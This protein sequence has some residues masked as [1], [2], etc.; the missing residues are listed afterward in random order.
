MANLHNLLN[1]ISFENLP[2]AWT[3]FDLASF[4]RA[5]SLWDYQQLALQN[6]LKALHKYYKDLGANKSS[7]FQWYTDNDIEL[8]SDFSLGKK[9]D[10]NSMLASFY[11]ITDS[12][13]SYHHFINRMGFW[14]ATGS[15]KTLVIVK[16]LEI[17]YTLIQRGEIP[18]HDV[19]VLTHREDLIQQLRDHVNDFNVSCKAPHIHLRELKE[20]P[21]IKRSANRMFGSQELTVFYYR[22]DNISDEQKERIIDFH[23]YEN[24]GKWYLLLDEAHK[25]DKDDSKRQHIYNILSRN[26]F[27]FNFSATFTDQRDIKT[28]AAEFNLASFIEK[29]YGKH[30]S[31]LKQENRAFKDKEDFSNEEKQRIVLQSLLT[32]AYI[33]KSREQLCNA[34]STL[35]FHRPLLLALVNSVNTEEADLKL[36]F[37]E[38]ERIGKGEISSQAFTAARSALKAELESEPEWLYEGINF[39]LDQSLLNS[40]TLNDLYKHIFNAESKGDIEVLVRPSND[41][42]LAF[43][44]KT[45]AAPFA[46]I[47]IGQNTEWLKDFLAGY[48]IVKGFEDESFFSHLNE[49]DSEIN[50]LMGSRSFYEGWDSNRPNVITFINIGT[51][52]EARKFVLQSVG[53]GV[54][55]EPMK[56]KRKRLESLH[57]T[58]EVADLLFQQAKPFL[59]AVQSLFI[60]GTKREALDTIFKGLVDEKEKQ[61][62]IEL[63]LDVNTSALSIYPVLIP[64]YRQLNGHLLVEQHEPRKFEIQSTESQLLKNYIDYLGDERLLL[65]RH[66]MTPQQIGLLEQALT[67]PDNFF[68]PNTTRKYGDIEILLPRLNQY[69]DIIPHEVEGFKIL[70]DEINHFKHIRVLLKDVKELQKKIDAV[71]LYK[72]PDAQEAQL[73]QQLRDG[74]LDIDQYTLAVKGLA[75]TEPEETFEHN[76]HRL[77]IKNITSHYYLPLLLSDDDRID[78]IS[79]IIKT[80]SEIRFVN[81]LE[82]YLKEPD[83]H[84]KQYDWWMFSRAE[85][86]LDKISIPYYDPTQNKMRDFH[87]DF[88]FWLANDAKYTILFVDPKGVRD[89]GWTYKVEGYKDLFL[90]NGK[91]KIFKHGKQSVQVALTLYTDDRNQVSAEYRDFWYD[92][93]RRI[94]EQSL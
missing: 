66:G 82:A 69:F 18:A 9:R 64:I 35:L 19:M 22:S 37:R 17:L 31:L 28:T 33:A 84:L 86:T 91:R 90:E 71:R 56:G 65:A 4:S 49:D 48:E 63:V 20:Y 34:T 45:S 24:N 11:S 21:E 1:D 47:K 74:K 50:L 12:K 93:P 52:A 32:L 88:I 13:I 38:L 23:N 44:L 83:N 40:L 75:R 41:K 62:G 57:N 39:A 36:F 70:E 54:R 89:I 10:N 15:G 53:R 77:H 42:E 81:Q 59:S 3:T 29:G 67:A 87:P 14:M 27:L 58:K 6:A 55:I 26:G 85:E 94:F 92:S 43:K 78:Y 61:E 79:R 68:N 7:F 8:D 16:M 60:F 5:K 73:K 30:I 2:P 51:G 46:L 76:G 25:G 80:P 72:D